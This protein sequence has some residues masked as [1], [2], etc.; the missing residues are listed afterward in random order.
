[1]HEVKWERGIKGRRQNDGA[2]HGQFSMKTSVGLFQI[3][4]ISIEKTSNHIGVRNLERSFVDFGKIRERTILL[5]IVGN[6]NWDEFH[7]YNVHLEICFV[8]FNCV[9][10]TCEKKDDYFLFVDVRCYIHQKH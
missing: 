5:G 7:W 4:D 6:Q 2:T 10:S 9:F 8:W 3:A 1:M